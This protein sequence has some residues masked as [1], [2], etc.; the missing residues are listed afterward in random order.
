LEGALGEDADG[1][2]IPCYHTLVDY[3][4]KLDL[5]DEGPLE[6]HKYLSTCK[7]LDE[8][9]AN[10]QVLVLV[11]DPTTSIINYFVT[12]KKEQCKEPQESPK[13]SC[14]PWVSTVSLAFSLSQF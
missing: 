3:V 11:E 14:T 8:G 6:V 13:V 2:G 12:E 5:V 9:F 1:T 4:A 7:V 10:V